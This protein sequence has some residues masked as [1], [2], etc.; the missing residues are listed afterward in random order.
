MPTIY[1]ISFKSYCLDIQTH[2][3]THTHTLNLLLYLDH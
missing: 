2:T 1:V 3:H